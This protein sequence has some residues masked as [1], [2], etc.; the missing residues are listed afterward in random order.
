VPHNRKEVGARMPAWLRDRPDDRLL[1]VLFAAMVALTIGVVGLDFYEMTLRAEAGEPDANPA[2]EI[3]ATPLPSVR[4]GDEE[5]QGPLR[6]ADGKLK[7]RMSFDLTANGRLLARGRI[8]PGT[9]EAFA[10]EVE[11]RG[12]YVKTVVLSSPGGSVSDAIKMGR[13]IRAKGFATEVENGGYCASSCPLVFA[14]G[15]ERRAGEKAAIGVHQIF[16]GAGQA[17]RLGDGMTGAQR[18]SA[19]CQRYLRDMGIDLEVW[20]HAMETPKERLYYFKPA[21]LLTLKLATH[22]AGRDKIA[23]AGVGR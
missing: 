6:K 18:V 15:V 5:R 14:G 17:G 13:L 23:A 16:A 19:E 7:E 20:V 3:P 10:A 4:E 21:E 8:D 9:A 11:K 12:A 2:L 1:R 22:Y